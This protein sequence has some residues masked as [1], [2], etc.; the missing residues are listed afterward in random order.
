MPAGREPAAKSFRDLEADL[1]AFSNAIVEIEGLIDITSDTDLAAVD[2]SIL[3]PGTAFYFCIPRNEKLLGYWDL[4]AD[5]LF[6]IRHC[7][8]IEGVVR[9]LPLFEPPIDPAMLVRAAAAGVDIGSALTDIYGSLPHYR[10]ATIYQK[11]SELANEL[12]SLG[13]SLLSALEKKDAEELALLRQRHEIELQS[14]VKLV[15]ERQIDEAKQ[16]LEGLRRSREMVEIRSRFYSSREF[17]NV[18]EAGHIERL[19]AA[20]NKQETLFLVELGAQLATLIPNF[21]IGSMGIS[22]PVLTSTYGGSDIAFGLQAYARYLSHQAGQMTYQANLMQIM[23]G[24]IRRQED[25][26]LQAELAAKELEQIDKQILAAEIRL[27]ISER[28][29]DHHLKQVEQAKEIDAYMLGKFTN[30]ELYSWMISQ[31]SSTYFQTYKLAYDIAKQAE[32]AFQ[33]EIVSDQTFIEFGYWDSLKKG[34]LAGEKLSHDLK[35]MDLTYLERN[36]REYEITKHISLSQLDPLALMQLKETGEC[37]VEIP[38]DLFDLD[39]PGM[40]MRR[41]KTVSL[42]IPCI[43]GPYASINCKLTLMSSSI[44]RESTL[45][46]GKYKRQ[47][48]SETRF[49]DQYGMIQSIVTSHGQNDSGMFE[50]NLRDERYLP[51]EGSGAI[52]TWKIELPGISNSFDIDSISD[53]VMHMKYTAREGGDLLKNSALEEIV[54]AMPRSGV[55][56]FSARRDFSTAWQRFMHPAGDADRQHLGLELTKRHLPFIYQKSN[57]A[58]KKVE[59]FLRVDDLTA[60][61]D[62]D[63]L[64]CSITA[65]NDAESEIVL[66]AD[67]SFGGVPHQTAAID[68]P[69]IGLWTISVQ[70]EKLSELDGSYVQVIEHDDEERHR[71]NK[72]VIQDLIVVLH[73]EVT[74]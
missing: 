11:A 62:G 65:P 9:Q 71:L 46:G 55:A 13:S 15:K 12:K 74:S 18:F 10:Y 1:D 20:N 61:A 25:W 53:V 32:K 73:Y 72:D 70:E 23:G 37:Y 69:A 48:S 66:P 56:L 34:L 26:D 35:R 68:S 30:T 47:D 6:K 60:Y 16:S 38:E 43:V 39:H 52:S 31:L 8:N 28:D 57:I 27:A 24:H 14:L 33:Y 58:V 42:T 19:N 44:R 45:L 67:D 63:A 3:P 41:I 49:H 22:S 7:M 2:D 50:V 59:V 51:F 40:Y 21:Q 4:V 36:K 29:L 64:T 17:L 5:R 54:E